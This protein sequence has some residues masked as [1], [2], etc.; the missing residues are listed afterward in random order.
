MKPFSKSPLA[1]LFLINPKRN[2]LV[3]I[4]FIFASLAEALGA[5]TFFVLLSILGDLGGSID[6]ALVD[7]IYNT[8]KNAD[9]LPIIESLLILTVI[10]FLIKNLVKLIA[11]RFIKYSAIDLATQLRLD[12]L[13]AVMN[14]E[15]EHLMHE[16]SG[17]FM[18]VMSNET[19]RTCTAYVSFMSA[20]SLAITAFA[21]IC[22]SI[23]ISWYATLFSLATIVTVVL[24]S[25]KLMQYSKRAGAQEG[26]LNHSLLVNLSDTLQA[27]KLYKVMAKEHLAQDLLESETK[28]LNLALRKGALI[29]AI[30]TSSQEPL[31]V[32]SV[33]A[34]LVVGLRIIDLPLASVLTL[35]II[36]FRI[37]ICIG[38]FQDEYNIALN[39]ISG[40]TITT[41]AIYGTE[42]CAEKLSAGRQPELNHGIELKDVC[43]SHL[44]A[45]EG[46]QHLNHISLKVPAKQLTVLIGESGAGKTT[47]VDLIVGLH[48]ADSG[49]IEIDG[50]NLN[51]LDLKAWRKMIGYVPQESLMLHD[52]VR[53]NLTLGEEYFTDQ[54]VHEALAA[55]HAHEFVL[56]LPEGLETVLE[57]SS[58]NIS[59]GQLQRLMIARALLHH[60]KLLILDEATASLDPKNTLNICETML[61]LKDTMSILMITHQP[62]I[63]QFADNIY[64]LKKGVL[65]KTYAGDKKLSHANTP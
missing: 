47:V 49:S 17:K 45:A 16:H 14:A 54:A 12:M 42:A 25:R 53:R 7:A 60:P 6:N 38:R 4:A 50:V 48:T 59:G 62:K 30:L 57:E 13:K 55:A 1:A 51:Q 31:F 8:V 44:K 3:V 18:N 24:L 23:T 64:A 37:L 40:F 2:T 26:K 35:A 28:G 32:I 19:S 9:I 39:T 58:R 43:F 22:I 34:A 5:S 10:G 52:T 29:N 21:Y 65:I 11:N 56:G 33:A 41:D 63:T 61:E 36:M 20:L 46:V 27:V 15:W